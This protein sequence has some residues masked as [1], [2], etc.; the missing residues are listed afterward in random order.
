MAKVVGIFGFSGDGKTSSTIINPDGSIDLSPEGYHGINPESH[1][2]LNIDQ[3][4]LP[5]PSLLSK[6]WCAENKNYRETSDIDVIG[7][8]L[9]VWAADPKIKSVSVDTLNSYL[10]FKELKDRRKMS[11]DQWR[12]LAID[13]VDLVTIANTV[14]REDQ[15]CYIM[16]HV[17]MITDIDGNE[18]K[19]L[20]TSGR[21]LKKIFVESLL[22]IVLF[23]RVE[24]GADGNNKYYFETKANRSSAKTPIGM[25]KDFLIPNSLALVDQS[26][27]EYYGI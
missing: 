2:I 21:K 20:A 5:F 3:K 18:R 22:P 17:E 7:R 4:S 19:A 25:F 26:V 8:T 12:D 9:K 13:V 1:G 23:T 24:P 11:F 6:Q 10:T 15:I 27:R 16:G 14:L